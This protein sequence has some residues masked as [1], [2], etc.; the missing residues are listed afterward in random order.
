MFIALFVPALASMSTKAVLTLVAQASVAT[1]AS[2]VTH[3]AY[4]KVKELVSS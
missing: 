4:Q 1:A 2:A 3:D